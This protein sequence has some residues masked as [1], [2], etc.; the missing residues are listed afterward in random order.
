MADDKPMDR[1]RFFRRGLAELLKPLDRKMAPIERVVHEIGKLDAPHPASAPP[2]APLNRAMPHVPSIAPPKAVRSTSPAN[3]PG[4]PSGHWLRPPGAISERD[5]GQ[6]CTREGQCVHACPAKCIK[7]DAT[8]VK[9]NGVPFIE[10]DTAACVVCTGLYCMDVCPSGALVPTAITDIDMGTAV[11][12]EEHCVRE[13]GENCTLC[14]DHCPLGE[15]AIR[16]DARGE[17]AV[18]PLGCIGCGVCQRDCPTTPKSIFVIPKSA[19]EW[20]G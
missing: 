2:S 13:R 3:V 9:G 14:I 7:I 16:L 19:K 4:A 12:R 15:V 18:N 8:R 10:A 6:E 20:A 17:V 11:W 1:R 5:F